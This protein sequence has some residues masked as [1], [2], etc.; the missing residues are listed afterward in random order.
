MPVG[1]AGLSGREKGTRKELFPLGGMIQ[2]ADF[3]DFKELAEDGMRMFGNQILG[4]DRL[5]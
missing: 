2:K 1:S 3:E 5:K 4:W